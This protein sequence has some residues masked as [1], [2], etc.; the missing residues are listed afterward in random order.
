MESSSSFIR[1]SHNLLKEGA[2][3]LKDMGYIALRLLRDREGVFC[4]E[5]P[6]FF[7]TANQYLYHGSIVSN[8]KEIINRAKILKKDLVI[9]VY[10]ENK[11]FIFNPEII[12]DEN[13]HWEN[14]RGYMTMYNWDINLGKELLT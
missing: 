12:L 14:M 5:Y 7:L 9:Y 10:S 2:K 3:K 11:F 8:Q 6:K 1:G 4:I 13:N